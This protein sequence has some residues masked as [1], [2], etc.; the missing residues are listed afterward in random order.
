M[1]IFDAEQNKYRE[2][3][4]R[5]FSHI[6]DDP[7]ECYKFYWLEA[8]IDLLEPERDVYR[9]EEIIDRMIAN[10]WHTVTTYHLWLGPRRA[11][12][13]EAPN[14][15]EKVINTLESLCL[16]TG[17]ASAEEVI[18]QL[19]IHDK[20]VRKY[21]SDL[22]LNVPYRLLSPF[23]K[24]I[25]GSDKRWGKREILDIINR[26]SEHSRLP[27]TFIRGKNQLD[28]RVVLDEAWKEFISE[29]TPILQGWI[30][31]HKVIFLQRR[32][33]TV[34]GIIYKLRAQGDLTR[35]L[36]AVRKLWKP[37]IETGMI[38][39]IYTGK[40]LTP[41]RYEIDHFIPWSYITNNELWD[42]IPADPSFNSSKSNSLPDWDTYSGRFFDSQY[43][44]YRSIHSNE[45]IMKLF[46]K[47]T[48]DN[49]SIQWGYD[50]L[51]KPDQTREEFS[52]VLSEN[53]KPIYDNAVRQGYKVQKWEQKAVYF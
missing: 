25:T 33:P 40:E 28:N 13:K 21:K 27:Y 22:T 9:F 29:E 1:N 30:E 19:H 16:L 18:R 44:L 14:Q 47:C 45:T 46:R 11:G 36:S 4:L 52:R 49:L 12:S 26:C 17:S 23:V 34:P 2:L 53:I 39:D 50:L 3:D 6:L 10:C 37:L 31:Y 51:N 20:A 8:L 38:L 43:Y 7:S 42:L 5:T 32:N 48:A 15:L 41:A 24:E 35:S